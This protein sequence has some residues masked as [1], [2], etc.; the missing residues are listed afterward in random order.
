MYYVFGFFEEIEERENNIS[1]YIEN[2]HINCTKIDFE[3]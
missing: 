2:I 3:K 1:G